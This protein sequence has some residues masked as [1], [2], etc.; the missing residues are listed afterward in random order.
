MGKHDEIVEKFINLNRGTIYGTMLGDATITYIPTGKYKR[1]D[2]SSIGGSVGMRIRHAADQEDLVRHKHEFMKEISGKLCTEKPQN[3]NWQIVHQFYTRKSKAWMPTYEL[4]Y[5]NARE[6]IDNS[7]HKRY[8]KRVTPEILDKV[9][10]RGMAWFFM[11]DG[12]CSHDKDGYTFFRLSTQGYTE[13]EDYL[14][15]DWLKDRYGVKASLNKSQNEGIRFASVDA[16]VV[17]IGRDEFEKIKSRIEPYF[18]PSLRYKLGYKKV[19]HS[20]YVT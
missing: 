3:T 14:I 13:E 10:D 1:K 8:F 16:F 20:L 18:I 2:G 17:Y 15:C 4:F 7:G 5:K 19:E 12:C 11:D 6:V 9:D